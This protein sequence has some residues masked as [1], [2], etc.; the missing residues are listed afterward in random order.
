MIQVLVHIN[1]Y[2]KLLSLQ[3]SRKRLKTHETVSLII[4]LSLS[5]S[6]SDSLSL[7][8]HALSYKV[9]ILHVSGR[10]WKELSFARQALYTMMI[11]ESLAPN[12]TTEASSI[13]R[14]EVFF[15]LCLSTFS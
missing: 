8:A 14:V 5:L 10:P 2:V 7:T 6:L 11:Y 4:A 9:G 13:L 1:L 12:G 15:S 3:K